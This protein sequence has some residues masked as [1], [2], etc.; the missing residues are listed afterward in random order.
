MSKYY[1]IA[2]LQ[3]I[4]RSWPECQALV[5]GKSGMVYKSFVLEEDARAYLEAYR[6][7]N[8]NGIPVPQESKKSKTKF[9]AFKNTNSIYATWAEC[10]AAIQGHNRPKYKSFPTREEAEAWLNDSTPTAPINRPATYQPVQT[11]QPA[12]NGPRT[13][14]VQ[15]YNGPNGIFGTI[16]VAEDINPTLLPY[17]GT[18]Y[19]VDGS[20]NTV[21]KVY[22]SGAIQIDPSGNIVQQR[23]FRGDLEKFASARNVAGEIHAFELAVDMAI[24]N[25][26][27]AITVICDYEGIFR[28]AAPTSVRVSNVVCWGN[29]KKTPIASHHADIL[30]KAAKAG[31]FQI[32]FIWVRGHMGLYHNEV[33]D[34]LAK[35]ACGIF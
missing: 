32:N 24:E 17:V 9:Y 1:A 19:S 25:G 15:N 14:E 31:I 13:I 10:E 20:F 33:V 28:W 29:K 12:N 8:P 21:T 23:Q 2:N 16:T 5:H 35:A 26:D 6:I 34:G 7:S 3:T 30:E 27:Q 18:R 4:V 11:I 22:G